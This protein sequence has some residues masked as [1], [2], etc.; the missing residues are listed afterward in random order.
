M[1]EN[2]GPSFYF[3]VLL[4]ILVTIMEPV[5][6]SEQTLIQLLLQRRN[7]ISQQMLAFIEE[8]STPVSEQS[9]NRR[10]K[11]FLKTSFFWEED[12]KHMPDDK[13]VEFYRIS[14]TVFSEILANIYPNVLTSSVAGDSADPAKKLAL[15][16]R[17]FATAD[18]FTTLA[19]LFR[20]GASTVRKIIRDVTEAITTHPF[21]K[22][23]VQFPSTEE[24]FYKISKEFFDMFQFPDCV[25]AVD[26]THVK[27][28]KPRVDPTSYFDYKKDYSVHLQ[29]V[30]DS[31]TRVLFYHIGAPGKNS[32]GGVAA[33]SGF[34]DLLKSGIIPDKYH[35]VGDPAFAL[36]P[37]LLTRYPGLYLLP[38]ESRYNY[39]QS[40]VRM[41]IESLFGRLKGRWK[42]LINP[43][44]F[45][46]LELVNRIIMSCVLLHNFLLTKDDTILHPRHH[47]QDK[48]Y[49]QLMD[50]LNE[51]KEKALEDVNKN[52]KR[53]KTSL[54]AKEKRVVVAGT[55]EKELS[56]ESCVLFL[57]M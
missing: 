19:H 46:D 31:K 5:D 50:V 7:I 37:N 23:L 34:N 20:V 11:R 9:R 44:P 45:R 29:A 3:A 53:R 8:T 42:V 57:G 43:M 27:I 52:R 36:H 51:A 56:E 54:S 10:Q 32:D 22:S 17:Y 2:I 12:C 28:Q 16:L 39:R 26:D 13:F 18:D 14:K 33:M 38:W 41:I 25:G 35:I 21:F 24:E 6:S 15:T 55:L 30:C 40:R 47:F 49:K 48:E 4:T 1:I